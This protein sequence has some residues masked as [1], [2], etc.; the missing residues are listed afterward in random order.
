VVFPVSHMGMLFSAGV[1]QA[2]CEFLRSR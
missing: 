1:A 2:V